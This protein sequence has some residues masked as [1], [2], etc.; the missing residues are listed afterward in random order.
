VPAVRG[1]LVTC[2][3]PLAGGAG[4]EDVAR[5]LGEAYA[6]EPFVRVLADGA[7]PDPKRVEGSNVCEIGAAADPRTGTA[8]VVA[9]VDNLVKG[10]A[11]QAIQ[12]MNLLFGFDETTALPAVGIYP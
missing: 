1:V 2:Y 7:M 11:G 3:A 5:A 4:A 6:G 9:A 10:A 8:I 12:N